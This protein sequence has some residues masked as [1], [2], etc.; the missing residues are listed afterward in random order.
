MLGYLSLD[1]ISSSKLTEAR[2]W[3]TVCFSEQIVSELLFIYT[4]LYRYG[5]RTRNLLGW[6]YFCFSLVSIFRGRF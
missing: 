4:M 3:K 6:F 2:S 5:Y 1:I